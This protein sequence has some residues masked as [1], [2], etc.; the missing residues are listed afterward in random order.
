[1]KSGK[2]EEEN[3]RLVENL[4]A[5]VRNRKPFLKDPEGLTEDIMNTIR[6]NPARKEQDIKKKT[7]ELA[8]LIILRRLL[9]AASVCLLLVFGYEE[10]VVVEK[11]SRLEKQSSAI[12]RS[13]QYQAALNLK[14]IMTVLTLNP[15]MI[16]QYPG[17]KTMK[18]DI[19]TIYKA[20][21]IA[22]AVGLSPDAF[23]LLNIAGYNPKNHDI[24]SFF[25]NFDATN[26]TIQ[27]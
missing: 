3:A 6:D 7:R 26:H 8:T 21:M 1:M 14:K 10:Y 16:N 27:R 13:S 23:K 5:S 24:I 12:S 17:F 20:A 4:L 9:A 18:I 19:R 25:N 2:V 11:I 22:D 15:Q